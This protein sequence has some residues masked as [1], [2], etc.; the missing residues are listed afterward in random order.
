MHGEALRR[1]Q[2]EHACGVEQRLRLQRPDI[3]HFEVVAVDPRH[4]LRSEEVDRRAFCTDVE[5]LAGNT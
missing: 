1:F 4:Q 5:L 3:D 2:I